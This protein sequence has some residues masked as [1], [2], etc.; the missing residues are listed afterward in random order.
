[1]TTILKHVRATAWPLTVGCAVFASNAASAAPPNA[2]KALAQLAQIS[3][4]VARFSAERIRAVGNAFSARNKAVPAR[5]FTM[6][7]VFLTVNYVTPSPSP[8]LRINDVVM[9][10]G[11]IPF[12]DNYE[13]T[14]V[15]VSGGPWN[16]PWMF[17]HYT[18]KPNALQPNVYDLE[19]VWVNPH[20]GGPEREHKYSMEVTD[21]QDD[22]P[23]YVI[24][25]GECHVGAPCPL[26]PGHAGAT[27]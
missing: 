4:A 25:K 15:V 16:H 22:C 2:E 7:H 27:N 21:T 23:S 9:L 26:D 24:F 20:N 12:S 11:P 6:C 17:G 3:Q 13:V 5:Q 8:H 14:P 10:V 19:G 1:M 18:A